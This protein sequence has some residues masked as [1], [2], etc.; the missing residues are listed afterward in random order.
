MNSK[1]FTRKGMERLLNQLNVH[2]KMAAFNNYELESMSDYKL[3]KT[4]NNRMDDLGLIKFNS[5][6]LEMELN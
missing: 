5:E 2:C 4:I 3:L 1:Y 6:E